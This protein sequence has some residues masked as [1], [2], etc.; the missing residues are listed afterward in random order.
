MKTFTGLPLNRNL[1]ASAHEP[2]IMQSSTYADLTPVFLAPWTGV[3]SVNSVKQSV[4][5]DKK[6][7]LSRFVR[8]PFFLA[9]GLR[10]R[11]RINYVKRLTKD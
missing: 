2:T 9:V 6:N 11:V 7:I 3:I 10:R 5:H 4:R 1:P 8:C